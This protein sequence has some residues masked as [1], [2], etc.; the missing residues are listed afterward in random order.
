[1]GQPQSLSEQPWGCTN[2]PKPGADPRAKRLKAPSPY[3]HPNQQL[4]NPQRAQGSHCE[5][6]ETS[7]HPQRGWSRGQHNPGFNIESFVNLHSP[8]TDPTPHK[9]THT[10]PSRALP[11]SPAQLSPCTLCEAGIYHPLQLHFFC[12]A[13]FPKQAGRGL[14][15]GTAS[16]PPCKAA[17]GTAPARMAAQ[18]HP[19]L[20]SHLPE[21]RQ[22]LL[23]LAPAHPSSLH[24][25]CTYCVFPGASSGNIPSVREHSSTAAR[26][27]LP[28]A[29]PPC[30]GQLY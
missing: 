26:A 27:S 2:P 10:P 30:C 12:K 24:C 3:R 29:L 7:T 18:A 1:M 15:T 6:L 14:C 4:R 8:R 5:G 28:P 9:H 13:A 20:C 19:G 25:Y 22:P 11:R 17:Q 21:P 16:Q 23:S